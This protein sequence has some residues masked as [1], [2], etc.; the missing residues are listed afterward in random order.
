ME[1]NSIKMHRLSRAWSQE[2]L[3]EISALSVRTI[4]RIEN[5]EKASLETLG[6]LAASFDVNVSELIDTE[7]GTTQAEAADQ[8][9][10][11]IKRRVAQEAKFFRS[12]FSAVLI[13]VGLVLIN[14]LIAPEPFWSGWV[15]AIWMGILVIRALKLFLFSSKFD[16]WKKN[17]CRRCYVNDTVNNQAVH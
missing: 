7:Q 2:Q 17:V 8:R 9:Y 6:A 5:G 3:A 16:E 13:C 14:I 10:A 12:L 4:Q 11:Q 1:N 15:T